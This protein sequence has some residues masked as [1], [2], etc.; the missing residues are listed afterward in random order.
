MK[1]QTALEPRRSSGCWSQGLCLTANVT[2]KSKIAA[3]SGVRCL[4]TKRSA[5]SCSRKCGRAR[6]CAVPSSQMCRHFRMGCG[7]R[8]RKG[9]TRMRFHL[10]CCCAPSRLAI[11]RRAPVVHFAGI[12]ATHPLVPQH[13]QR[14]VCAASGGENSTTSGWEPRTTRS[15]ISMGCT[16]LWMVPGRPIRWRLR[17]RLNRFRGIVWMM[18]MYLRATANRLIN[19]MASAG[20]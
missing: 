11:G 6:F 14:R 3:A 10:A 17:L 7:G 5:R 9:R 1:T 18:F 13:W 16:G 4:D 2:R 20:I 12:P 19:G 8:R 15:S